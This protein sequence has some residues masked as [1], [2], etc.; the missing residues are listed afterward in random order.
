MKAAYETPVLLLSGDVVGDT[1]TGDAIGLE[2]DDETKFNVRCPGGV[3]Y[4]L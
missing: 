2:C 3:G 1:L 4:Y